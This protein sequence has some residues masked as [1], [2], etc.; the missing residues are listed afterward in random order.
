MSIAISQ[1]EKTGVPDLQ[2]KTS[3]VSFKG[4]PEDNHDVMMRSVSHGDAQSRLT[5][6]F[7]TS[8][9]TDDDPPSCQEFDSEEME[10]IRQMNHE[11]VMK[12]SKK[13]LT[14]TEK[15]LRKEQAMQRK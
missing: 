5:S 15:K 14:K 6:G 10:E 2:R 11:K 4:V 1:E 8:L 12:K 13:Q 9:S 3:V 7:S